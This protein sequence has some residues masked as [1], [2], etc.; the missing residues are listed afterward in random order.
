MHGCVERSSPSPASTNEQYSVNMHRP[1][2][3]Q[4]GNTLELKSTDGL[5]RLTRRLRISLDNVAEL[6]CGLTWKNFRPKSL[7][8]IRQRTNPTRQRGLG[9]TPRR[10]VGFVS[11]ICARRV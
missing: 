5:T 3:R 6:P 2:V 4:G 8:A 7:W 9:E 11:Q 10:R 1:A